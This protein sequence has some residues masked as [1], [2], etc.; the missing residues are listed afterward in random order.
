MELVAAPLATPDATP[1]AI[2]EE[3]RG[4][5]L[6]FLHTF[7]TSVN[8]WPAA[9]HSNRCGDK[10]QVSETGFT[11][12]RH[13]TFEYLVSSRRDRNSMIGAGPSPRVH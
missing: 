4:G 2:R 13:A 8:L 5:H 6:Y 10:F 7:V 9:S 3:L 12:G 11:G 1:W